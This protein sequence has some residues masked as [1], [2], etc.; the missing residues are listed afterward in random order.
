MRAIAAVFRPKLNVRFSARPRRPAMTEMGAKRPSG[1]QETLEIRAIAGAASSQR[2][3]THSYSEWK[4]MEGGQQP[5]A[6]CHTDG[7]R[8]ALL[9]LWEGWRAPVGEACAPLQLAPQK[10]T[11]TAHCTDIGRQ[12]E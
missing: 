9:G 7:A 1:R 3:P 12:V 6:I 10:P 8:R 5:D 2:R 11:Q 4:A